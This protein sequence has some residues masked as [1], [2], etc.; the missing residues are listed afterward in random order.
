M[1]KSQVTYCSVKPGRYRPVLPGVRSGIV[2]LTDS[3]PDVEDDEVEEVKAPSVEEEEAKMP[4][5]FIWRAEGGVGVPP[6]PEELGESEGEENDDEEKK[7]LEK[8]EEEG[9]GE[10]GEE[11][12][13]EVS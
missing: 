6:E 3:T 10:G 11:K 13:Q 1:T 5:S 7:K 12:E 8:K 9:G 2:M 4:E